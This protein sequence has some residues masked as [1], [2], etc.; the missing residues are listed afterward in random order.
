MR[1]VIRRTS[2]IQIQV[3][4]FPGQL[5]SWTVNKGMSYTIP[6]KIEP[7]T[8]SVGSRIPD[9]SLPGYVREYAIFLRRA[10]SLAGDLNAV[11]KTET[12]FDNVTVVERDSPMNWISFSKDKEDGQITI[13]IPD[14]S[15]YR[16]DPE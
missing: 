1:V 2:G 4:P 15:A 5:D 7:A 13:Y 12:D 6:R 16:K 10:A 9:A 14:Q 11:F 3:W 8:I